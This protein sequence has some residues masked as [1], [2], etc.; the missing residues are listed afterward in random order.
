MYR[1]VITIIIIV[2]TMLITLSGCKTNSSEKD[3]YKQQHIPVI[4]NV[5]YI[6]ISKHDESVH[7]SHFDQEVLDAILQGLIV[8]AKPSFIDDPEH[9]GEMYS[10]EVV[11]DTASITY[12]VNDLRYTD[13]QDSS[14]KL[15]ATIEDNQS[16]AW[17]LPSAWMRMLLKENPTGA[18]EPLLHVSINENSNSVIV[19]ANR[20]MKRNSVYQAI[21]DTVTF[22]GKQEERKLD[23]SVHITDPQ[24]FV[25]RFNTLEEKEAVYFRLDAVQ[26]LSGESFAGD[27]PSYRNQVILY[28]KPTFQ[29]LRW[30]DMHGEAVREQRL[31]SA[32]LLQPIRNANQQQTSLMVYD[33]QDRQTLINLDT[34]E[35]KPIHI[36]QW[37]GA[38]NGYGNDYGTSVLFTDQVLDG[39]SYVV[40][41][42]R[43]IYRYSASD[44]V[45]ELQKI[46]DSDRPIYG[47]A[48]SPDNCR[49]AI[50]V[51]SDP[52]IGPEADLIVMDEEGH[53][54][55]IKERASY[56]GHSEG[57]LF[58]YPM[59]WLN[60]QTIVVPIIGLGEDSFYRGKAYIHLNEDKTELE[61]D[62]LLPDAALSLLE[63]VV[64][65][66]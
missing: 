43:Y 44:D 24:R 16:L 28:G 29:G 49:I 56:V 31:D 50:L 46:Y 47:I 23:Y 14:V 41:G 9:V 5:Q 18:T 37:P 63:T 60:E 33:T 42:N 15:Y 66:I 11:S 40:K 53:I 54:L 65:D 45:D 21:K 62:I 27:R 25:V 30:V 7:L 13:A 20:D 58:V 51:P 55:F 12:K 19:L 26:T 17:E 64:G 32:L 22:T 52:S 1:S 57:F 36:K 38:E 4:D 35:T 48:T 3:S 6:K 8:D 34:G 61:A 2:L 10:M 39:T 59:T